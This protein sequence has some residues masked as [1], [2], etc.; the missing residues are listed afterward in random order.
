MG[1]VATDKSVHTIA[2]LHE[3]NHQNSVSM[4]VSTATNFVLQLPTQGLDMLS[5]E[6]GII[7]MYRITR[8]ARQYLIVG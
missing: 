3:A 8:K 5:F 7:C 1:V 4:Y 6:N 2:A